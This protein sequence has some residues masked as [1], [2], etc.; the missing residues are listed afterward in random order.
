MAAVSGPETASEV[1]GTPTVVRARADYFPYDPDEPHYT[2]HVAALDTILDRVDDPGVRDWLTPF[3]A[4]FKRHFLA[5]HRRLDDGSTVADHELDAMQD[6]HRK[7]EPHVRLAGNPLDAAMDHTWRRMGFPPL[8][9]VVDRLA[10][11]EHLSAEQIRQGM[12]PPATGPDLELAVLRRAGVSMRA[13]PRRYGEAFE[14]DDDGRPL[15][16]DGN[17][18]RN[19][20]YDQF[21][22]LSAEDPGR[23][24]GVDDAFWA[25]AIACLIP[26]A[27]VAGLLLHSFLA[28]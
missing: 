25:G 14:T 17:V 21:L 28:G 20:P 1:G 26:V 22:A 11:K 18:L 24:A 13:G 27:I 2:A 15:D 9:G 3:L 10:W 5:L 7:M 8:F 12:W 19:N 6:L 16:A 23:T 4:E